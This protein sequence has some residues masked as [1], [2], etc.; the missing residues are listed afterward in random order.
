MTPLRKPQ[1]GLRDALWTMLVLALMCG[2]YAS[3]QD[4]QQRIK[5]RND[6]LLMPYGFRPDERIDP[7]DEYIKSLQARNTG[8]NA[9]PD[10]QLID[11]FQAI[12]IVREIVAAEL[13]AEAIPV[14]EVTAVGSEF[15]VVVEYASG[16]DEKPIA[17]LAATLL[18]PF[19]GFWV[20]G[21]IAERIRF[22]LSCAVIA[23]IEFVCIGIL[24][25]TIL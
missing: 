24:F 9:A 23:L 6:L 20:G 8:K 15:R 19:F 18:T 14:F 11:K 3:N 13:P 4:Q 7:R 17:I 16:R 5:S 1:F 2:W 22:A 25:R 12:E 10:G 21:L